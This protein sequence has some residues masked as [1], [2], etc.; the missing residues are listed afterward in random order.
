MNTRL[1]VE[2]PVTEIVTGVDL[3]EW[4]IMIA[5][6]ER[7]PLS[8]DRVRQSGHAIEARVCAEDPGENFLPQSGR[9]T[10]WQ[11]PQGADI[12]VDHALCEGDRL[13]RIRFNDR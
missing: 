4:Q 12:R 10:I 8:Q 2:H 7:L 11:P 9:V 13:N 5:S 1:Q 6:G 3:V